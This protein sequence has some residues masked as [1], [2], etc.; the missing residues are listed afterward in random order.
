VSIEELVHNMTINSNVTKP[1]PS[2]IAVFD[3]V[4]TTGRHFKAVQRLL[5]GSFPAT[6]IVGL[7]IA[8]QSA[9]QLPL[10]K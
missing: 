3:D 5:A 4:I 9:R 10:I 6:P 8:P 1:Q 7:F 2:A